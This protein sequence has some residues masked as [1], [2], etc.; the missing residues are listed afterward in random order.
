MRWIVST[1]HYQKL[2]KLLIDHF[3]SQ[4]VVIAEHNFKLIEHITQFTYN[5][6]AV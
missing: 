3:R 2:I 1:R 4:F 5:A 6:A